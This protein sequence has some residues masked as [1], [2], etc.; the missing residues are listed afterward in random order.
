MDVTRDSIVVRGSSRADCVH[1]MAHVPSCAVFWPNR[2]SNFWRPAFEFAALEHDRTVFALDWDGHGQ[3]AFSGRDDL[4]MED[5]VTDLL[6]FADTLN[7]QRM[8]LLAHS[9]SAVSGI[10]YC[11]R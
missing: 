10:E 9:M 4:S 1:A 6:D 7:I 3:T 8:I 2:S 5:L 11:G